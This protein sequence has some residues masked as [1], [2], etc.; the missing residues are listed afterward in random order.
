MQCVTH[1]LHTGFS[2][3]LVATVTVG[4]ICAS[5]FCL[6]GSADPFPTPPPPSPPLFFWGVRLSNRLEEFFVAFNCNSMGELS[7]VSHSYLGN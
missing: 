2:T 6:V 1:V 5:F 4:G 3:G 7:F